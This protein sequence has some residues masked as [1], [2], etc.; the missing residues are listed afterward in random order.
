MLLRQNSSLSSM[1]EN[2]RFPRVGA[3]GR[4]QQAQQAYAKHK[5][6]MML[7]IL[8][9][10]EQQ[11]QHGEKTGRTLYGHLFGRAGRKALAAA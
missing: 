4:F 5:G 10:R 11:Q 9:R 7:L 3:A 1:D 2:A 6:L 8:S